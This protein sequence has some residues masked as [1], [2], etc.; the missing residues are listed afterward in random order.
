ME[1]SSKMPNIQASQN[2]AGIKTNFTEK[3]SKEEVAELKGQIAKNAREMM[4]SSTTIQSTLASKKD[5]FTSLYEDFQSFLGDIGY[6]GKPIAELSQ[7]EAAELVSEDGIFGIKQTSERIANFV[8]N[9]AGGDEERLRAGREGM[10]QGF[11]DAENMWG[12]ELPE[13]SQK[14]MQAATEMVDKAMH[15][16][17]FSI[18]NQEA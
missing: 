9:G 16:L 14:T 5:D 11:K 8:I 6:E 10:L 2:S 3:I 13:I 15:D 17:G 1:I 7:E 12:G 18:I 4:L